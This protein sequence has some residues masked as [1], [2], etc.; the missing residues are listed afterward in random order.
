VKEATCN[1]KDSDLFLF[2]LFILFIYFIYLFYLFILFVLFFFFFYFLGLAS[3]VTNNN[4]YDIKEEM[5]A[6]DT[7]AKS[8]EISLR[9]YAEVSD[10]FEMTEEG[11]RV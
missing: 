2:Y 5:N 8:L 6:M 10:A 1:N 4:N 11:R 9:G 7:H 3:F